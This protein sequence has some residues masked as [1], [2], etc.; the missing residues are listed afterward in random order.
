MFSDFA[1]LWN[2]SSGQRHSLLEKII[3]RLN[4]K[5]PN[6]GDILYILLE[7]SSKLSSGKVLHVQSPEVE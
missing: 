1:P 2:N 3:P 6:W 7:P 4:L 5:D